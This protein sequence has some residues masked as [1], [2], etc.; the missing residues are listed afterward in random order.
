MASHANHIAV[1][2]AFSPLSLSLRRP[3]PLGS[4]GF[5][6]VFRCPI[7]FDAPVNELR[8]PRAE[9]E[10]P[11]EG[12]NPELARRNDEIVVRY[13]ARFDKQNLRARVRAAL[14]EQLPLGEPSAEKIAAALNLSLRSLQRR[15]AEEHSSYDELLN[16]TRR[17]LAL[18]Y[19]RD[20]RYA[21]SEAATCWDFPTPAATRARSSAGPASRPASSGRR[22]M[23]LAE[24]APRH[25]LPALERASMRRAGPGWRWRR[26]RHQDA[27]SSRASTG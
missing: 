12:A 18:S 20:T 4:D 16:D 9:L 8:L 13:L 1:G 14:A 26:F 10:R 2:R 15:L 11:L 19:A 5:R 27:P 24:R 17:E 22:W 21:V 23:L 6:R 25:S 3:A 7:Q